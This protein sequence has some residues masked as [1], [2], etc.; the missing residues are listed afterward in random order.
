MQKPPILEHFTKIT[1]KVLKCTKSLHGIDKDLHPFCGVAALILGRALVDSKG[2]LLMRNRLVEWKRLNRPR[3]LHKKCHQ[4][5][6]KAHISYANE[7]TLNGMSNLIRS[8][9]EDY[10]V[11]IFSTRTYNTPL[12]VE[13]PNGLE[14]TIYLL[15]DDVQHYS[16][17]KRLNAF[18][19]KMGVYCDTCYKFFSGTDTHH[20]CDTALCKQC[21]TARCNPQRKN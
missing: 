9:F 12:A 11:V 1:H 17:I 2:T 20:I 5:C 13:N 7:V 18:F 8:E 6:H 15:L 16:L 19:G 21:K 3:T 4:L 14:G 10:K